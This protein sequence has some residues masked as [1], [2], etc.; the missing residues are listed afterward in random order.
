VLV[1][2]GVSDNLFN[3]NQALKNLAPHAEARARSVFVGFHGGTRCRPCCPAARRPA[4][5][6]LGG[7]GTDPCS[8]ALQGGKGD[9]TSLQLRFFDVHLKGARGTCPGEGATR[10]SRPTATACRRRARH[11]HGARRRHR[12]DAGRRGRP[13]AV[14]PARQRPAH[15]AGTPY[16]DAKVTTL[17]PE[18]RAFFALA[19]GTSRRR[20]RVHSNLL[21]H[22]EPTA[23]PV[24]APHRAAGVA[25]EVPKGQQLFLVVSPVAE[26]YP[27]TRAGSRAS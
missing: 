6:A 22:R 25:V 5:V 20:H 24:R 21:P 19:V 1:R 8:T 2:Q 15:V 26:M 16:V 7:D 3:L 9:F 10:W 27:A 12:H 18:A 4:P 11:R 13:R 17:T 23:S 14:R